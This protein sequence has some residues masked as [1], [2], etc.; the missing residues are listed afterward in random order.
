MG[1]FK[2]KFDGY[3][4]VARENPT[5]EDWATAEVYVNMIDI[6]LRGNVP[7]IG[8]ITVRT[9]PDVVS[10]GQV[11][12]PGGPRIPAKC[13][14]GAAA[15]FDVPGMSTLFNKEP[16]LLMNNG[17]KSIPPVEDPNGVAHLSYLPLYDRT[18]PKG[19]PVAYLTSLK[20]P[21]GNYITR[22]QAKRIRE[23]FSG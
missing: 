11:L 12:A 20:Y 1:E 4:R 19:R 3:F 9:N 14:I 2:V 15:I 18:Y 7:G 5:T 8:Q 21:V 23:Q 6:F 16:I 13:R 10:P 22:A 17:I